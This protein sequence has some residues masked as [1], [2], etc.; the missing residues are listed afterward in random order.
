MIFAHP[1][2]MKMAEVPWLECDGATAL[3]TKTRRPL[4]LVDTE[5]APAIH[6]SEQTRR[7]RRL[8]NVGDRPRNAR[9]GS[10]ALQALPGCDRHTCLRSLVVL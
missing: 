3:A 5:Q 7:L 9:V 1:L 2:R 4:C 10:L 8:N 6:F